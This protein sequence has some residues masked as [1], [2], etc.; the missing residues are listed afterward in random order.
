MK[1]SYYKQT[2]EFGFT[3]AEIRSIIDDHDE[4]DEDAFMDALTGC[5]GIVDEEHFITFDCDVEKAI[6]CG[7]E[8]RELHSWEWD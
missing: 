3:R 1:L 5:T 2:S 7:L 8:G 6:Q 4:I